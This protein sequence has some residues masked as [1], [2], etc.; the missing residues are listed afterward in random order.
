MLVR[1]IVKFNRENYYNGAIQTEWFYDSERVDGIAKSYVFH[2]P[3]YYG[4]TR[5]DVETGDHKLLDTASFAKTVSDKL[6]TKAD[7]NFLLTIAGYGTGKSHLAVT[8]GALFSGNEELKSSIVSN[9]RSVDS[10]IA[11]SI[12]KNKKRNLV[13]ALNG[14]RNFNLDAEVL[15]CVRL[16]LERDGVS[17]DI[18]KGLTKTYDIARYF[19]SSNFE[20][21]IEEFEKA[22]KEQGVG[23]T[24]KDL[25][26]YIIANIECDSH[27]LSIVN[28]VY[29]L[30]TGDSLHWD[31][32]ISAG[33]IISVVSEELCG[34]DKPYNKVLILFDEFGRYIEYVAANPTIAGD[35]S[36]QQIFEAIQTASGNAVFVGFIQYE[37]EAYLSHIDKTANVI[38]YVGR[39][40]VSEKYYLS[41]NFET[42]LANLL[43]K[44]KD[45]SFEN[46]I[47]HSFDRY[48]SFHEKV[49][50]AI[51]R[52]SGSKTLKNVWESEN[53]Y[54]SIIMEGCY[55]MHPMTV[56]ILSNSASWMQQRSTIAFCAEMYESVAEDEV[57]DN[58]LPYI[59]PID[60]V[61]SGIFSEM[62]S[63][64]E[65]GLVKSQYCMLYNEICVKVGDKLNEI[66]KKLLKAVLI[67]RVAGFSFYDKDDACLAF[68]YCSNLKEEEIKAALR[69]LEDRHGVIAFDDQAKTYDLI[70]EASGF[71]E[72]KRVYSRYRTGNKVDIED[73]DEDTL[74]SL[75]L[76]DPVETSFGQENHISSL[77]WKYKKSLIDASTITE[78]F[79]NTQ[80]ITVSAATNGEDLRGVLLYAYC[81]ENSDKESERL[82]RL[83]KKTGLDKTPIIILF[84]DDTDG[85]IVKA[86]TIKSTLNRFSASD[87]ERFSK[88]IISQKRKQDKI[89]LQK[90]NALVMERQYVTEDGIRSYD[91]RVNVLCTQRFSNVYSTPVPFAFDGFENSK[92]TQAKKTFANI[93]VKIFDQTLMNIQSYQAL[94]IA[95]KNRVQAC[96]AVGQKYSWQVFND[97]CQ[98]VTPQND[99]VLCIYNEVEQAINTEDIYTVG[100]LFGKYLYSPYG[101]NVYAITLFVVYFIQKQG[102]KIICYYGNDRLNTQNLSNSILKDGKLKYSELQRVSIQK[103]KNADTDY[104]AELCNSILENTDVYKC[105]TLRDKLERLIREEGVKSKDQMLVGQAKMRLDDGD[106]IC[107]KLSEKEKKIKQ[108]LDDASAKFVIHKFVGVFEYLDDP[109]GIIEEGLPYIY[110][111]NYVEVIKSSKNKINHLM[112]DTFSNAL[113]S[114][115]CSDITNLGSFQNTYKKVIKTLIDNGYAEQASSTEQRVNQIV[116]ETKAKNQYNQALG[117]FEME[118]ALNSD[119]S[120]IDYGECVE[121]ISK[122]ESWK[123]FF[124]DAEM[125]GSIKEPLVEKVNDVCLRLNER[126]Q[127]LIEK[128]SSIESE[129]ETV[130]NIDDLLAVKDDVDELLGFHFEEAVSDRLGEIGKSIDSVSARI[131]DIPDTLDEVEELTKQI[132]TKNPYDRVYFSSLMEVKEKLLMDE[133]QW[134]TKT[135]EPA[136]TTD[137]LD[138]QQC[139]HFIDKLRNVPT[140]V[141]GKTNKRVQQAI[142]NIEKK[143]HEC[144]V[145]GVYSLFNALSEEE[146]EEFLKLINRF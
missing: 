137:S 129:L 46:I 70:A 33:D 68:R 132:K 122:F 104:M 58:W 127:V 74:K 13:I 59:Y 47:G 142:V 43:E 16:E 139:A 11:A 106:S 1:D 27:V 54:R 100:K 144:K 96:L 14:M 91:S 41:T 92:S 51:R 2:G 103:N 57:A 48:E 76:I 102:N 36:L 121:R 66:E 18:L 94:S 143:L 50:V 123:K 84:L 40:S 9:L 17:E 19:V 6:Y 10:G 29:L 118:F 60:I 135:L 65:K 89:I 15:R 80:V 107:H 128:I 141:S 55:P 4:V 130:D 120:R 3:K 133:Q 98:L 101:M 136:E 105:S 30:V 114:L 90:F 7:N 116:E 77:E 109:T 112:G 113:I 63:S 87:S 49:R 53:L 56:W 31:Q 61:D 99:I 126:K 24:G 71:N 20:R 78:S 95:D 83:A 67:T 42:I 12:E 82:V 79:L 25:K 111:Q 85:E 110:N 45:G 44:S 108:Y 115:R 28:A 119:I 21:C 97:S 72:F 124:S 93:C 81:S 35:A 69:E 62:L 39:Y 34:I 131:E 146:K 117:E 134:I 8:L 52:W 38:R 75:R 125:P 140:F 86:L 88:H 64:E 37:L 23:Y 32:G 145:Q 22:A 5:K 26:D 138:A 73:A